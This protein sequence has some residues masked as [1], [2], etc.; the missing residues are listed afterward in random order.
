[1]STSKIP[2]PKDLL[3]SKSTEVVQAKEAAEISSIRRKERIAAIEDYFAFVVT[4]VLGLA[5]T[6]V[7]GLVWLKPG[8]LP[9]TSNQGLYVL[10]GGIALLA[11]KR[12]ITMLARINS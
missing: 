12:V 10:S 3:I 9:L 7:G 8:F 2:D 1:M 4:K 11:G 6:I 5:G